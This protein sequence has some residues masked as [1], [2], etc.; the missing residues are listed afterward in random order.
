M[1]KI[2]HV[3]GLGSIGLRHARN[4]LGMGHRVHGTDP[5]ETRGP[6][7][8][9][10]GGE[11]FRGDGIREDVDAVVIASPTSEHLAHLE[12][13]VARGFH[14]LV[15]KPIA[16]GRPEHVKRVLAVAA[17][18]KLVVMTGFN[19]RFHSCV[20][21]VRERVTQ[22][23]RPLWASFTVAQKN[24]RYQRDSVVLNWASHEI[25]LALHLLGPARVTAASIRPPHGTDTLAD[26]T[27]LHTS[28]CQTTIHA[29]YF[30][31]PEIRRGT[32]VC[33]NG[34]M[35]MDMVTRRTEVRS[36]FKER[37]AVYP[38]QDTFEANY[39]AE[40]A[41]FLDRTEGRETLGASGDD[42]L[43]ALQIC[44]DARQMAGT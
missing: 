33:E 17:K 32:I 31:D 25:D 36:R 30:T 43:A 26:I 23:G 29:D 10:I 2:V 39:R 14:V 44:V 9:Q 6:L 40:M 34:Q 24:A 20:R 11:Y 8:T 18:K 28:G 37:M 27:L 4:L 38:G 42:G 16:D 13:A 35:S 21:H 12:S 41:A 19:L 7:L 22:F 1:S 15:E 3:I 5:N